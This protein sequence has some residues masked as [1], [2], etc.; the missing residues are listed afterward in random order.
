MKAERCCPRG[1]C[2]YSPEAVRFHLGRLQAYEIAGEEASVRY[3]SPNLDAR[4]GLAPGDGP[5]AALDVR[6]AIEQLRSEGQPVNA[7]LV[8]SKLCP[9]SVEA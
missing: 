3:A 4:F 5:T 7:E 8:A 6:R 1:A 2:E 9:W